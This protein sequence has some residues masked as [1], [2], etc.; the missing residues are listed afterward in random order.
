MPDAMLMGEGEN[1]R[2]WLGSLFPLFIHGTPTNFTVLFLA[3]FAQIV[4]TWGVQRKATG[5]GPQDS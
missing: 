1:K 4:K 2:G 3:K 5:K